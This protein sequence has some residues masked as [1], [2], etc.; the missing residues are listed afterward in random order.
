MNKIIQ[1]LF[2]TVP[3]DVCNIIYQYYKPQYL[4]FIHSLSRCEL[5]HVLGGCNRVDIRKDTYIFHK[6][7]FR[8]TIFGTQFYTLTDYGC[9][10]DNFCIDNRDNLKKRCTDNGIEF[11]DRTPSK[12]LI[13]KLMKL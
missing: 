7:Y 4:E 8:Y 1:Q 9:Y 6:D 2:P 5:K 11:K 13:K 10:F 12:C 3:T